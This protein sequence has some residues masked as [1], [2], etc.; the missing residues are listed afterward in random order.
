MLLS[1][2]VA[3]TGLEDGGW[4]ALLSFSS[5]ELS[6]LLSTLINFFCCLQINFWFILEIENHAGYIYV[7]L[8]S[9]KKTFTMFAKNKLNY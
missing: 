7:Q 8:N 9:L 2:C 5:T 6:I 3:F 4:F 1:G